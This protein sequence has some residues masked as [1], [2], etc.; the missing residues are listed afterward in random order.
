MATRPRGPRPLGNRARSVVDEALIRLHTVDQLAGG[1]A[2]AAERSN[3]QLVVARVAR[4]HDEVAAIRTALG[5]AA[6]GRY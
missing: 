2:S 1:V 4:I 3:Y 5:N 6:M